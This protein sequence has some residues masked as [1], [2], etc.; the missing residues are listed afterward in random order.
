[1]SI[2]QH[3]EDLQHD[4]AE[5]S[6]EETASDSS[7]GEGEFIAEPKKPLN[8]Q[9]VAFFA[10]LAVACGATYF[11]YVR[12][13][14]QTA[15]AAPA[16]S[17][18][19]EAVKT[20]LSGGNSNIKSMRVWLQDMNKVVEKFTTFS[21]A[22]QVPLDG[23]IKNPFH[24]ETDRPKENVNL[25]EIAR[26]K[27]LEEQ[28]QAAIQAAQALQL[29]SIVV[30][31]TRRGCMINGAFYAEGQTVGDFKVEKINATTVIVREGQFR[32]QLRMPK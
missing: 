21:S 3:D 32:F 17:Q 19:E 15:T 8:K 29:Q 4:D 20:F 31:D 18:H 11:M 5:M 10:I 2:D 26:K 1:M 7:P 25:E 30:S 13:G 28:R 9:M 14:P 6:G 23:L 24:F 16:V 22:K 27:K 12:S